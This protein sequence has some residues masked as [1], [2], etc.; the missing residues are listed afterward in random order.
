MRE[1]SEEDKKKLEVFEN[2][3]YNRKNEMNCENCMNNMGYPSDYLP[4][5]E[6]YC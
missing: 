1:L 3:F 5:G 4:C 2:F 6:H